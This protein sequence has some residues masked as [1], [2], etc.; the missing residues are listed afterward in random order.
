MLS[1]F[2]EE[3]KPYLNHYV[4]AMDFDFCG[5][6][7]T[8]F[9]NATHSNTDKLIKNSANIPLD[10]SGDPEFQL[11]SLKLG[12]TD[13]NNQNRA[14]YVV[15]PF[16]VLPKDI[17]S[18]FKIRIEEKGLAFLKNHARTV[19]QTAAE[20]VCGFNQD[21]TSEFERFRSHIATGRRFSDLSLEEVRIFYSA[22]K[23]KE[24]TAGLFS[25]SNVLY[26]ND[27]KFPSKV[28]TSTLISKSAVNNQLLRAVKKV[29][30]SD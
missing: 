30:D 17:A 11:T 1:H 10:T 22:L 15:F 8:L 24:K 9:S 4:I 23:S 12:D 25:L 3:I 6:L 5:E 13:I 28:E 19:R 20:L 16:N 29:C 18:S 7:V 2:C 27:V 26:Q 21:K 14:Q